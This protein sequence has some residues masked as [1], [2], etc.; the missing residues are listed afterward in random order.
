[1]NGSALNVSAVNHPDHAARECFP[2][3]QG[4]ERAATAGPD[5][6][7]EVP[8]RLWLRHVDSLTWIVATSFIASLILAISAA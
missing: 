3:P 4:Y 6:V 1:L 7:A 5:R 2:H 8:A